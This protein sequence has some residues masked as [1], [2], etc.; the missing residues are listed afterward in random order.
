MPLFSFEGLAPQVHE[1][2]FVALVG[3]GTA[4]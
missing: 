2:A 4:Q 3:H 1:G